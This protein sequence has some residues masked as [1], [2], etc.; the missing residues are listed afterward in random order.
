[1]KTLEHY[2]D[3]AHASAGLK[4]LLLQIASICAE[5]SGQIRLG[6]LA[7]IHGERRRFPLPSRPA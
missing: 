5:I 7:G 1:V 2:L 4:R 3:E 6:A